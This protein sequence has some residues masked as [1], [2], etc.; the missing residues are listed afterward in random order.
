MPGIAGEYGDQGVHVVGGH[1]SAGPVDQQRPRSRLPTASATACMVGGA[2]AT[3]VGRSPLVVVS[4]KGWCHEWV[5]TSST[6]QAHS[7]PRSAAR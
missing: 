7:P 5:P 4:L 1:P 3:M 2:N 6:L